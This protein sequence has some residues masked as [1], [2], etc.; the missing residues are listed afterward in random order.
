MSFPRRSPERLETMLASLLE[1]LSVRPVEVL[2]SEQAYFAVY[3][4]EQGLVTGSIHA[5]LVPFWADRLGKTS[6]VALQAS[7]LSGSFAKP[8]G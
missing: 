1:G 8:H 5:G 3:E 7:R 2:R 6:L 4:N